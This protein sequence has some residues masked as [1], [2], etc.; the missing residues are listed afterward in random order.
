MK[1]CAHCGITIEMLRRRYPWS[2]RVRKENP[3][4]LPIGKTFP[5]ARRK[6]GDASPY[7]IILQGTWPAYFHGRIYQMFEDEV[8]L[9]SPTQRAS[10]QEVDHYE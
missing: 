1:S 5:F 4:S 8:E 3:Y 10:A 7:P 2:A 6:E 9:F